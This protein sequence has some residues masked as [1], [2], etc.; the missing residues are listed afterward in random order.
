ME[1][2]TIK[3]ISASGIYKTCCAKFRCDECNLLQGDC[4]RCSFN[5]KVWDKL[6][7]YENIGISPEQATVQLSL[8]T[9][10]RE[11]AE[12]VS[13]D[14][15]ELKKRLRNAE[16]NNNTL[17]KEK[18]P[19][20]LFTKIAEV[21]KSCEQCKHSQRYGA[22]G[23]RYCRILG[24][25]FSGDINPPYREVPDECPIVIYNSK[26]E[27]QS[28]EIAGDDYTT[29]CKYCENSTN[30]KA[31]HPRLLDIADVEEAKQVFLWLW[32]KTIQI[33]AKI[34][35]EEFHVRADIKYCPMCGRRLKK[36]EDTK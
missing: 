19:G 18:T 16:V 2:L 33:T 14:L 9:E 35:G 36:M 24:E 20:D 5:E 1:R 13:A 3:D 15:K 17:L 25:Y 23:D 12:E 31:E 6:S 34:K 28:R 29:R 11:Y 21:P 4:S 27:N 22:V 8:L 30:I 32:R 7:A 26:L 10:Y